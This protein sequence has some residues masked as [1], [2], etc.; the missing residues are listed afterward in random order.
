MNAFQQYL[1]REI[2]DLQNTVPVDFMEQAAK[3][4]EGFFG[5]FVS[6]EHATQAIRLFE[7]STGAGLE[8]ELGE[9]LQFLF[10]GTGVYGPE[11]SEFVVA[12]PNNVLSWEQNGVRR[13][14]SYV[15]NPGIEQKFTEED[16]KD[17]AID[18]ILSGEYEE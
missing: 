17:A 11:Q 16:I 18:A 10:T 8:I 7:S 5:R 1:E 6:A 4:L 12:S 2:A 15:Y 9:P 13:F 14:A 3:G